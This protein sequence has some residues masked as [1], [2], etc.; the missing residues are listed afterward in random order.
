MPGERY[1][2]K[3]THGTGCTYSAVITAELAK[4]KSI[5]DAVTLAKRYMDMAIKYTLNSDMDKVQSI[6]SSFVEVE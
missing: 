6:T 5:E 1:A 2:T 3:H 4:G